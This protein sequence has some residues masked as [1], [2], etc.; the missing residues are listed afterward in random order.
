[1]R[2]SISVCGASIAPATAY[3]PPGRSATAFGQ[4]K[5]GQAYSSGRPGNED[6]FD[7]DA[8]AMQHVF[9]RRVGARDCRKFGVAPVTVHRMCFAGRSHCELRE[10]AVALAAQCPAFECTVIDV[11]AQHVLYQY[12]LSDAARGQSLLM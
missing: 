9:R 12:P 7:A 5:C 2:R 11:R 10:P 8:V 1:M 4:L 3:A 6:P